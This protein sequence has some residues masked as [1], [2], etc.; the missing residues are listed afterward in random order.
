LHTPQEILKTNQLNLYPA[1]ATF[2]NYNKRTGKMMRKQQE[3][4]PMS[5]RQNSIA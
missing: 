3:Q 5:I 4:P 2:E 1:E